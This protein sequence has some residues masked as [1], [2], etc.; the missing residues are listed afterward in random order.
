MQSISNPRHAPATGPASP[1]SGGQSSITQTLSA[2]ARGILTYALNR[3]RWLQFVV[4]VL[5]IASLVHL[6]NVGNIPDSWHVG[7]TLGTGVNDAVDWVTH[8]FS[9]FFRGVNQVALTYLLIPLRHWLMRIPWW[10]AAGVLTLVSYRL[11]SKRF[12]AVTLGMILFVVLIGLYSYAMETLALVIVATVVCVGIG[13]PTGVLASKSDRFEAGLKPL[14]DTMQ[15]MP[16][17]VYLIPVL[18]LFGLGDVPGIIATF[19]YAAPPIIRLTNLGIRQVDPTIVE[20]ARAF[21]ATPFQMLV[22]IEV[23]LAI[24]TIMAGLNQTIMMALAMVVIAAMIG[25]GGLGGEVLAGINRLDTAQGLFAGLGI[26]VMAVI[27]DRITQSLAQSRQ[28]PSTN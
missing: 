15:T 13:L 7:R 6:S 24:P 25:A 1:V 23:P 2:T 14:L 19:I 27:L 4:V 8:H 18:F 3:P 22:K 10:V 17:F 16:S 20:A 26:V 11:V 5:I 9:A 21:G 28:A 12:A